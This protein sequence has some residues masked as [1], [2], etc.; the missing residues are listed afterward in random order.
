MK[1][2]QQRNRH[3]TAQQNYIATKSLILTDSAR[4]KYM[5]I[6]I[7]KPTNSSHAFTAITKDE[8]PIEV[9]NNKQQNLDHPHQCKEHDPE[10][11]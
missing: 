2:F 10:H 8:H 6:T 3:K 5:T 9:N 4:Q 7:A 1:H 11:K